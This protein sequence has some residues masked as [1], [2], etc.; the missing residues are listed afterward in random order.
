VYW[1][2]GP[3]YITH[4]LEQHAAMCKAN[5]YCNALGLRTWQIE[6]D[7]DDDDDGKVDKPVTPRRHH[8]NPHNRGV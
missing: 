1:D 7:D 4:F 8:L 2:R 3:N 6:D 5:K